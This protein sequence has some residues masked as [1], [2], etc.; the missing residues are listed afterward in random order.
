MNDDLRAHLEFFGDLGVDGVR[1]E[2]EWRTRAERRVAESSPAEPDEPAE[3]VETDEVK[4]S[5]EPVAPAVHP[6]KINLVA[7]SVVPVAIVAVR[8][9]A[10]SRAARP[11]GMGARPTN[12]TAGGT[13]AIT[14]APPRTP[15]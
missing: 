15:P 10:W 1:L 4:P 14:T 2:P 8:S 9:S 12:R 11:S 13:A 6:G 3:P 7:R 5:V